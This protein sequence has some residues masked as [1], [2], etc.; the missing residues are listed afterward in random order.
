M[1]LII[2]GGRDYRMTRDDVDYLYKLNL[3]E[4]ITEIV[5]GVCAGADLC[6]EV[7]AH[8][9]DISIKHFPATDYGKWPSCGPKRNE[10]MAKY[11]D[12]VVLFPGGKGTEN[13][14]NNAIKYNLQIFDRRF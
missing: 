9:N 11:A 8:C 4:E 7:F 5:S 10:A 3:K 14:Y 1:K 6:G 2:A 13:M 12:A